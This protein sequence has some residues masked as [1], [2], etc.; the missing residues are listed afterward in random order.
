MRIPLWEVCNSIVVVLNSYVIVTS[1]IG[2]LDQAYPCLS[3]TEAMY[4]IG[5][6]MADVS[7]TQLNPLNYIAI[8]VG[9]TL[10][11]HSTL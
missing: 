7:L 6:K 8:I 1:P 3:R 5:M 2:Y 11:N 9:S 10:Q 4:I